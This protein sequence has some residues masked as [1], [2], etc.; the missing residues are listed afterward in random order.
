[1]TIQIILNMIHAASV[2]LVASRGDAK[3]IRGVATSLRNIAA[4]ID[5]LADALREE[6]WTP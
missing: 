3:H 5:L 4:D 1:M 2:R 6:G